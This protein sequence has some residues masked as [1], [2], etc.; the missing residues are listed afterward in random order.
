MTCLNKNKGAACKYEG[1]RYSDNTPPKRPPKD[2]LVFLDSNESVS[3]HP[4][5]P[6]SPEGPSIQPEQSEQDHSPFIH[7]K[8]V[9]DPPS[10]AL[11]A[12]RA[13]G[14]TEC[15][16]HSTASSLSILPSI[17]SQTIPRPLQIPLSFIPP[18]R[19]QVSWIA[20]SDMD[21]RLY[22][23]SHRPRESLSTGGLKARSLAAA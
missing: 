14:V 15:P 12:V 8:V 3:S 1:S 10:G 9:T 13:L 7:E 19:M 6:N 18:E 20:G 17:H 16:P 22:V 5:P 2:V 11:V 4:L 21:M 23:L